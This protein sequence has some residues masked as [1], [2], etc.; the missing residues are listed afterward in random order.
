MIDR[1]IHDKKRYKE[2]LMKTSKVHMKITTEKIKIKGKQS[3]FVVKIDL[4]KK[5]ENA[6]RLYMG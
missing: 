4:C 5:T 3:Y 6:R 2:K 1:N